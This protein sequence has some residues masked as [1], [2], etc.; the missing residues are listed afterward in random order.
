MVVAAI[1]LGRQ[2]R[3]GVDAGEHDPPAWPAKLSQSTPPVPPQPL[4]GSVAE[5]HLDLGG[6]HEVLAIA[7]RILVMREG[8]QMGIFDAEEATQ[9]RV[10]RLATGQADAVEAA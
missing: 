5:L 4:G 7:D 3:V 8:R 1:A 10:M 6:Q 9:Q 2:S